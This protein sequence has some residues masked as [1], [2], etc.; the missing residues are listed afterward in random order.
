MLV[1]AQLL[2]WIPLL[3]DGSGYDREETTQETPVSYRE[4]VEVK[5]SVVGGVVEVRGAKRLGSA[6]LGPEL[7]SLR[8]STFSA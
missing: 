7:A 8:R 1:V 3:S 6:A 2:E 5:S 4:E